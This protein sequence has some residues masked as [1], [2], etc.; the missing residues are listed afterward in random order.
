MAVPTIE[1]TDA[2]IAAMYEQLANQVGAGVA[3]QQQN[4][5]NTSNTIGSVYDEMTQALTNQANATA[6]GLGQQFNMLGIGAATDSATNDLRGQLNQALISAAR[7]KAAEQ[8]GLTQQGGSYARSGF[9]SVSNVRREGGRVRTDVGNKLRDILAQMETAKIQ[10]EGQLELQ[11]LQGEIE[12]AQMRAAGRGGG[13]G[14]GGGSPL[15]M[16]RA[17][18]LGLEILEKQQGLEQGPDFPWSKSGQGG[19][20]KFLNSPSDYWVSGAGPKVRG[21]LQDIISQ[22]S[23]SATNPANI[24]AGLR[25]PYTISLGLVNKSPT[26]RTPYYRDA[27]RQALQIYFGKAR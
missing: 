10:S 27:M 5:T 13:G 4:F 7:R 3:A 2:A 22:A 18:L 8:A 16:L 26:V 6:S 20:N 25:D 17:Q 15:D 12:L 1:E 9:E 24:A 11:K 14:G 19:L 23:A 21:S